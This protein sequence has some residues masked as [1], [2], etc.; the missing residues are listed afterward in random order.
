MHTTTLI[1]GLDLTAAVLASS[2][3]IAGSHKA[4]FPMHESHMSLEEGEKS[5]FLY[6]CTLHTPSLTSV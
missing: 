2:H 3:F 5:P 6:A 1:R 4:S